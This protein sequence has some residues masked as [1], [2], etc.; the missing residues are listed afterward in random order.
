MECEV[1]VDL[2]T[3]RE[4]RPRIQNQINVDL[5]RPD[6]ETVTVKPRK[7]GNTVLSAKVTKLV[8]DF[9]FKMDNE[10]SLTINMVIF[11]MTMP[12][13]FYEGIVRK[14]MPD[15]QAKKFV[16]GLKNQR[17]KDLFRSVLRTRLNRIKTRPASGEIRKED[18]ERKEIPIRKKKI[19]KKMPDSQTKK[20]ILGLKNQKIKDFFRA[21]LRSRIDRMKKRLAAGE[22]RK[23][24]FV[25]KNIPLE[26]YR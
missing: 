13:G 2:E 10:L 20:F 1:N 24:D 4:S 7:V 11:K 15:S 17:L 16:L 21:V 5:D 9:V 23:E 18:Y 14:M 12:S 8:E 22:I 25:K 19:K 26:Y 3:S 6:L